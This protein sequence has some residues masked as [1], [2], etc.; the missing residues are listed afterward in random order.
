MRSFQ[1]LLLLKGMVNQVT[2]I[3]PGIQLKL[4]TRPIFG[5]SILLRIYIDVTTYSYM[6]LGSTYIALLL[7]PCGAERGPENHGRSAYELEPAE[8]YLA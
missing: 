2:P 4:F 8:R 6:P 3:R 1:L 5:A 7:A